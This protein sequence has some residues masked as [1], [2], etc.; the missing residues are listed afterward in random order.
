[1]VRRSA[2][3]CYK[4]ESEGEVIKAFEQQ[5]AMYSTK[6]PNPKLVDGAAYITIGDPYKASGDRVPGRWKGKGFQVPLIPKNAENGNFG[7]LEYR[8]DPFAEME[9]YTRTQPLDKRK[10]GF[11]TKDAFRRGEFTATIRTEQYRDLL[12]REQRIVDRQHDPAAAAAII[13][14]ASKRH[15]ETRSFPAHLP[16][17]NFLYDIGR[18][19][20]TAFDPKNT[21]DRF[22][23]LSMHQDKR[24]GED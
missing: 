19:H 21:R 10:K 9:R 6:R 18:A 1:Y 23:T 12:K 3:S 15:A 22:Y 7:K 2:R 11:G 14:R 5:T 16:E 4:T 17:T 8:S 24:M 13:E 20:V